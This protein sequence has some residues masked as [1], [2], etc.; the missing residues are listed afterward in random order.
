MRSLPGR[1][2]G[3]GTEENL[4]LNQRAWLV[5]WVER[6]YDAFQW[7]EHSSC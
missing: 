2:G 3:V 4:A 5:K 6:R 1:D 7:H